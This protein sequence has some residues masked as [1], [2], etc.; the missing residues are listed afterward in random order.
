MCAVLREAAMSSQSNQT[1]LST[2]TLF[3][4]AGTLV[5]CALPALFVTL[6]AGAALAG[7]VSTAPWLIA[8][9]KYKAWTFGVSGVMIL[10]AGF[11]RWK[12][13]NAPCP[14][15][16]GQ[17]KACTRLRKVS[18]WMYWESVAVWAIGFFFAFIAVHIFY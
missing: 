3:T 7:L 18:G 15:D 8:L 4:S 10:L 16:P 11:M 14:I 5:C 9:S 1:W 6:G 2:L 12:A 13:R 17:A